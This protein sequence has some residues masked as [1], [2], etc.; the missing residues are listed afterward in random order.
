V[1]DGMSREKAL[2]AL[3][4]SGARMLDLEDRVGSLETGKDA[5]FL[6]LNGDPFSVYTHV[7][8]TWVEG[9]KVFDRDNPDQLPYA[10]GGHEVFRGDNFDHYST[11]GAQ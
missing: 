7:Q 6:L 3:T 11:G 8:Q 2:E 5:D 1:R 10:T 9:I 4:L